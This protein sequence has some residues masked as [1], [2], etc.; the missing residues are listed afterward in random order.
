MSS[1][2]HILLILV[3]LKM[4]VKSQLKI[5]FH[6]LTGACKYGYVSG[7]FFFIILVYMDLFYL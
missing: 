4:A 5:E 7:N 2:Q 3:A 6:R 1:E